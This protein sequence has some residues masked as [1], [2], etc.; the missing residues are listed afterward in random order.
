MIDIW[1]Y[2]ALT[3]LAILTGFIDAVAGGGGLLMMPALLFSGVPPLNALATNKLQSLLGITTALSQFVRKGFVDWRRHG[4]TIGFVFVGCAGG[5]MAVQSL[6][7]DTLMLII[8]VLLVLLS[9][10]ILL[11]TR[12]GDKEGPDRTGP[13]GYAPVGGIVGAYDGFFGP[14]A[15][16]FYV[17][18]ISYFRGLG[19]T[20]ATALTKLFNMTSNL[21]AVIMWA[22]LGHMWWG[23]G[24]CI[25]LGAMTGAYIGSHTAMKHGARLIRPLVVTLSLGMTAKLLWDYFA[26]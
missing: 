20:R 23:L 18:S 4:L 11:G 12:R 6:S 9:L 21:A 24:L 8:P 17:A 22:W 14:A 2:P 13:K 5:V 19:L 10:Y 25:A 15:G 7:N 3:A 26:A 16:A 1:A